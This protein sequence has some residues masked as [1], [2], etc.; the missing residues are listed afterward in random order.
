[1][2][3]VSKYKKIK[4]VDPYAK[5]KGR[6]GSIGNSRSAE[7]VWGTGDNGRREKKR[8]LKAQR[9]QAKKL[10]NATE[11]RRRMREAAG[12]GGFDLP[13]SGKD[14]FDLAD[15]VGSVRKEKRRRLDHGLVD[16]N[17]VA[18]SVA[19]T[20]AG[21]SSSVGTSKNEKN[22]NTKKGAADAKNKSS[23]DVAQRASIPETDADEKRV[24]RILKLGAATTASSA[25]MGGAGGKAALGGGKSNSGRSATH[26]SASTNQKAAGMTFTGRREGE[27]MRAF[28]RRIKEETRLIL[29]D[30]AAG[31]KITSKEK[32]QRKKEFF[33]TLKGKKKRSKGGG[34]GG[35]NYA[36]SSDEEV[37]RNGDDDG[38]FVTGERAVAAAAA[39][40]GSAL[41]DQVERPPTFELLPRGAT[42]AVSKDGT[43]NGSKR[44]GGMDSKKIRAEQRAMDA[45]RAK[46]QAQYAVI[47]Q[48]RKR[49]GEFHL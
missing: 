9:H 25:S 45:L 49:A 14:D 7:Y 41:H 44:G 34:G 17:S 24:A 27:S 47:K 11:G 33:K 22:K 26:P 35:R 18:S 23:S 1:M 32:A 29:L 6:G 37:D 21:T 16:P 40:R 42:R 3:R 5:N 31:S 39:A 19:A 10:A 48:K 36:G 30:Q 2:G 15:I 12:S 28:E 38:A 8:S 13:T 46:V 4:S 43:G 20:A